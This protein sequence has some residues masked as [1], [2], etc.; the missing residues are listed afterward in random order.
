MLGLCEDGVIAI[1]LYFRLPHAIGLGAIDA[2]VR[3][4]NGDCALASRI[5]ALALTLNIHLSPRVVQEVR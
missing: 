1:A 3:L 5:G 2:A 4:R